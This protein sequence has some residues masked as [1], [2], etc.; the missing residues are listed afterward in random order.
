MTVMKYVEG[1]N[2]GK[3]VLY[4]LSTCGWCRMTKALLKKLGVGYYY[5]NVDLLER[6]EQQEALEE[7]KKWNPKMIYPTLVINDEKVISPYKEQRI[8]KELG[9]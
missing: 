7:V 2:K 1:K 8:I 9:G 5:L 3:V 4:A 6:K